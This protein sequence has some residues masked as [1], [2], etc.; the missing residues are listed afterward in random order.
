MA[1]FMPESSST[2]QRI[3][4]P[5][6]SGTRAPDASGWRNCRSSQIG[7]SKGRTGAPPLTGGNSSGR[8][9]EPSAGAFL[10]LPPAFTGTLI[11]A[12]SPCKCA[13]CLITTVRSRLVKW[14]NNPESR[15]A[16]FRPRS[17]HTLAHFGSTVWANLERM[18]W[19]CT[20][21][22]P[23]PPR[24]M[25][26]ESGRSD[27]SSDGRSIATVGISLIHSC[28]SLIRW[29]G[30]WLYLFWLPNPISSI[31]KNKL[32]AC[33]LLFLLW[34]AVSK[35]LKDYGCMAVNVNHL[36]APRGSWLWI[37]KNWSCSMRGAHRKQCSLTLPKP[38]FKITRLKMPLTLLLSGLM[39]Q[40]PP[41]CGVL[42]FF[43]K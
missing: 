39:A 20:P 42:S 2:P 35:Y 40:L 31:P 5:T 36:L 38:D 28:A 33:K 4:G 13:R 34:E 21:S 18:A 22:W 30:I 9:S 3:A 6:S 23:P 43:I 19:A 16:L 24:N 26:L 11:L 41:G 7:T 29:W 32:S 17:S 1:S 10:F 14:A 27:G 12:S 37:L 15:V 8:S 25:K